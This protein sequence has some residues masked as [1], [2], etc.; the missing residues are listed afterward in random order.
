MTILSVIDALVVRILTLIPGR[1]ATVSRT[2]RRSVNK[3]D[4]VVWL[5]WEKVP[6]D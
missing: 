4:D 2:N 6:L 3:G 1:I 5:T